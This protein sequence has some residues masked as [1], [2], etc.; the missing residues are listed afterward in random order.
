MLTTPPNPFNNS[1]IPT[2]ATLLGGPCVIGGDF[3]TIPASIGSW[4]LLRFRCEGSCAA[5]LAEMRSPWRQSFRKPRLKLAVHGLCLCDVQGGLWQLE[6]S[7]LQDAAMTKA[8]H[9]LTLP[10]PHEASTCRMVSFPRR[11]TSWRVQRSCFKPGYE[12]SPFFPTKQ[13]QALP[14]L[15]GHLH[16]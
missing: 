7:Q 8:Q 10:R 2:T 16:L 9:D 12:V 13:P 6:S 1:S 5:F 4:R 11:H 15:Q 3:G 14:Q